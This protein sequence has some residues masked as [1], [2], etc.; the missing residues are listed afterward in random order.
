MQLLLLFKN[1]DSAVRADARANAAGG[2][3][4]AVLGEYILIPF[5]IDLTADSQHLSGAKLNAIA[6]AFAALGDYF[7]FRHVNI[8]LH[9]SI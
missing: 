3:L 7:N 8:S 9:S 1:F 6:A 5:G 2:A 4:I